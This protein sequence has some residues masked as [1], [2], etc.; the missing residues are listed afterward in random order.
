[1]MAPIELAMLVPFNSPLNQID[2]VNFINVA[3]QSNL[4]SA[5]PLKLTQGVV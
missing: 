5:I 2:P 4:F 1:M 3:S